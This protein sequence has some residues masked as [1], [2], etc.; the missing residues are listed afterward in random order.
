MM[1]VQR[2]VRLLILLSLSTSPFHRGVHSFCTNIKDNNACI[3]ISISTSTST[4]SSALSSTSSKTKASAPVEKDNNNDNNDEV[5][6]THTHA[7]VNGN[8]ILDSNNNKLKSTPALKDIADERR[9]YELNLG[10]AL[11]TLRSDYPKIFESCPDFSIYHNSLEVI[12]PSGV[13]LHGLNNYKNF[14]RVLR[15][16]VSFFYCAEKSSITF[17]L[18]YDWARNNIRVAWHA[19]L[20]PKAIYG[21]VRHP[22]YVDGVSVYETDNLGAITQHRVEHLM[23]NDNPATLPNGIFH[24]INN[25]AQG[26]PVLGVEGTAGSTSSASTKIEPPRYVLFSSDA[27]TA[28]TADASSSFN[29]ESFEQRNS[30]R[31]K[32][33]LKPLTPDEFLEIEHK[34]RL[35][36]QETQLRREQLLSKAAAE[37]Q[38]KSR[39][40]KGGLF[41][42]LFE[43][44]CESNFDCERPEVC[45]DLI[46]KKMCCSSGVKI[47]N[48]MPGQQRQPMLIPVPARP[49]GDRSPNY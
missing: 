31:K 2:N 14:F 13:T 24:A 39:A 7:R 29:E 48:M 19:T 23:L 33:G 25:E 5:V 36:E 20:I 38:Q 4:S 40:K 11:D 45:C 18:V 35:L 12:D 30:Y 42:N 9:E 1:Y 3:S 44:T 47:S 46:V 15:G 43:D 41:S 32:Y 16:I 22:L 34:T 17:R 10:K 21:G 6:D 37:Q 27:A 28:T 26:I 49:D 8:N